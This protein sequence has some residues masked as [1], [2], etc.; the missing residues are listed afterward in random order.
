[1]VHQTFECITATI[2]RKPCAMMRIRSEEIP[3]RRN[4]KDN[5]GR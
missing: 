1:M 4:S 3:K 5:L 2:V